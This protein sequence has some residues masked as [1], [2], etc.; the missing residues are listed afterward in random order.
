MLLSGK[1]MYV[2]AL[3]QGVLVINSQ[4]VAIDL[5]KKRSNIHSDQPAYT[6]NNRQI[7]HFSYNTKG[8]N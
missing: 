6:S 8:F 4:H 7:H 3:G 1:M 2:S 5:L